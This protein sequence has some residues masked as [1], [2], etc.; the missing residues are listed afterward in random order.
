MGGAISPTISLRQSHPGFLLI[1]SKLK[2]G[3][4][5]GKGMV[6]GLRFSSKSPSI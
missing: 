6:T 2:D 4:E 1:K 5:L 3:L